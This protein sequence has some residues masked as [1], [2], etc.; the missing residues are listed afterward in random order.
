MQKNIN[1][2]NVKGY[3]KKVNKYIY[4]KLQSK[5]QQKR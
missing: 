3:L 1:E 5:I 2:E 4:K